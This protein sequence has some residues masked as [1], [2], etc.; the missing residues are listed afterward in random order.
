LFGVDKA[1]GAPLDIRKKID[2]I[3]GD[4]HS[5]D[6]RDLLAGRIAAIDETV[7]G[8]LSLDP[9]PPPRAG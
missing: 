9:A 4:T 8:P 1:T 7:N 6:H 2:A 5:E 3:Y